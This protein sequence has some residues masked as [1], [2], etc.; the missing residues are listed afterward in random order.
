MKKGFSPNKKQSIII[1]RLDVRQ[2]EKLEEIAGKFN[3]KI[4]EV[5]REAITIWINMNSKGA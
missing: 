2:K 1:C 3:M 5:V 4:S